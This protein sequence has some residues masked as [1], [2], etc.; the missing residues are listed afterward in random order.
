VGK[1]RVHGAVWVK[2]DPFEDLPWVI[3]HN[4]ETEILTE[5]DHRP[6]RSVGCMGWEESL[7]RFRRLRHAILKVA[8]DEVNYPQVLGVVEGAELSFW[9]QRGGGLASWEFIYR[10]LVESVRTLNDQKKAR[11][12]EIVAT[13][14]ALFRSV[15]PPDVA[16]NLGGYPATVQPTQGGQQIGSG[17]TGVDPNDPTDQSGVT[18]TVIGQG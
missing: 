3:L 17:G 1:V 7:P 2:V 9:A 14:G 6:H 4:A 12:V 18:V 15:P 11:R 5:V 8:E 10:A 16:E 13:R